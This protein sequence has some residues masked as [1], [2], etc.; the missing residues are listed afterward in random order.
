MLNRMAEPPANRTRQPDPPAARRPLPPA[1]G[2]QLNA[3]IA[4]KLD[5]VA[6]LLDEQGANPFRVRAYR[7]GA[8]AL[9]RLGEPASHILDAEGLDGLER[10]PGIGITLARTIRDIVRFGYS[11]MLARMRGDLD[12]L[13]LLGTVPGIGKRLAGRLHDELGLDTLEDLEAAAGDGRLETLA[14]F[15]PKRLAG[16]RAVLAQRLGR[17]RR[18]R[19]EERPPS[20]AELL[21]VDR[22][23]PRKGRGRS[24]A[25]HCAQTIQPRRPALVAGAA[26]G[27]WRAALH[28]ALLEHRARAP[29]GHDA[30]LGGHLRGRRPNR[31]AMD[32]RDGACRPTGRTPRGARTG[33]GV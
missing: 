33:G 2:D 17:V 24:A 21:D 27:A 6:A 22:E 20:V 3:A 1:G 25:A 16:I 14:G 18:P 5:E 4:G 11:P 8:N 12:P 32:R 26:H 15:G 28:G 10:L 19:S 9:R 30:G 7:R 23:Y 13:R 29:A 31:W